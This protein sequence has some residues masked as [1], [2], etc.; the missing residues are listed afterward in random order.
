MERC[1]ICPRMCGADRENGRGRCGE[2]NRIR[3]ARAALHMWEEPCVSG[4]NGSGAVF[5][6]GC[7][8]GCEFCQNVEIS[9]A[10]K[11]TE[12]SPQRLEEIFFE[13]KSKGAHNINLVTP[14]HFS[15]V[16]VKVLERVKPSLGI[17]VVWNCGGYERVET[18]RMLDGLVDVYL[19]DMKFYSS[20]V[21]AKYADAPDYF[22]VASKAAAEMLRQTG[23]VEFTSDG[24]I[25]RG[26]IIR[27]LVLPSNA[28]DSIA[29]MRWIAENFSTDDIRV[30]IMSQYVPNGEDNVHKE[31]KRRVY[32]YEYDKVTAEAVRLGLDGYI[33]EKS[34]ASKDY[35]PDFG[36]EGV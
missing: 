36:F 6:S 33:Q 1:Y 5:F 4:T 17:P 35:L 18:L 2:S 10:G 3:L 30:S 21:S 29:V 22:E 11:G 14:T 25:Q 23:K 32:G 27:H 34:S 9:S 15:A 31:L 8:L 20:E 7:P 12:V 26:M 19:P 24:L 16:L 13:L 28:A